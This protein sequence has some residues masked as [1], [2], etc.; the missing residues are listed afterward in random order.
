MLHKIKN[1]WSQNQIQ[2]ILTPLKQMFYEPSNQ[3]YFLYKYYMCLQDRKYRWV[4][5]CKQSLALKIINM[6][7]P[8]E[9]KISSLP[10][11]FTHTKQLTKMSTAFASFC[12]MKNLL[13]FMT[14]NGVKPCGKPMCQLFFE[15]NIFHQLALTLL[16]FKKLSGQVM[17]QVLPFDYFDFSNLPFLPINTWHMASK[18]FFHQ[19]HFKGKWMH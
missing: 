12:C 9:R 2:L 17:C 8:W 1:T 19:I 16:I 7:R 3:T 6:F 4:V 10:S 13:C 14:T 18:H 15:W 5:L 11:F